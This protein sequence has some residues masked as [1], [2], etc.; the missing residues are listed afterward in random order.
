MVLIDGSQVSGSLQNPS[1]VHEF[2]RRVEAGEFREVSHVGAGQQYTTTAMVR[3]EHEIIDRMQDGNRRDYSDPMLVSPRVRIATEDRHPELNASQRQAVDEI[4]LS[5]EKVVGLDGI[6]GAGKTT[7]LSVIRRR[8]GG[9][10]LQGGRFRANVPR[11]AEAWGSRH[12]DIHTTEASGTWTAAGY[13]R[14]NDS[15]CSTNHRWHRPGKS[16][17]L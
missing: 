13:R 14:E 1:A 3:M 8:R 17:S 4:L 15:M 16:M 6:A 12:G 2:E 7:T 5:R 9:R 10:G 11:G